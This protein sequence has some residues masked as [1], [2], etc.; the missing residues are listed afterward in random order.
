MKHKFSKKK[1]G[2]HPSISTSSLPDIVFMLLFFFM[3]STVMR[4][5][6]LKVNISTPN[7]SEA[8]KVEHKNLVSY[9]Y[10]GKPIGRYQKVHGSE[11]V[12]QLNDA[13]ARLKDIQSFVVSSRSTK[14]ET[15]AR[16]LTFSIKADRDITM[17]IISDIK[18]EL[19]E[20]QAYKLNYAA[21]IGDAME[22]LK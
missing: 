21:N 18:D 11:P 7:A 1:N 19:R 8:K 12:I 4:E 9:I 16:Q 5:V 3:V 13:I 14:N 15:E 10:V 6:Q 20:A 17:G 22:N 2:R